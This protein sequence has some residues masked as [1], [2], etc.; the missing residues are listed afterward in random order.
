MDIAR[1]AAAL[2][3]LPLL[4]ACGATEAEAGGDLTKVTF[5]LA[6][7]P[8]GS[9]GG[10]FAAIDQG[11]YKEEG[12]SV[13]PVRGYG[14]TR[15][16]NEIDQGQFDYGYADPISVILNRAKKG[17][18]VM[19]GALNTVWP[20][21]LCYDAGKRTVDD[22]AGLKGLVLGGGSTSPIQSLLPVWLARNGLPADHIKIIKMD[23]AVIDSALVQ[24]KI[25][26]SDCWA[27]S[28]RATVLDLAK[29]AGKQIKWLDYRDHNLDMYGNGI[30]T[31]ADRLQ[32]DPEQVRKFLRATYKGY[33]Y[34]KANPDEVV[35]IIAKK[36]PE[37]NREVLASQVG[38][39]NTL[40]GDGKGL[41]DE[42]RMKS[43]AEIIG[44]AFKVD[45]PA[46]DVYTNDYLK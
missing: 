2:L 33:A 26:L 4:A 13:E 27:G 46:T 10:V 8:Q 37:M 25:D 34:M 24:G 20:G 31:S 45:V 30:V 38:D 28:N 1:R 6:W 43:T 35:G 17:G 36:Y 15:T 7:F 12:L 3:V 18:T 39:M 44:T 42:A 16:V 9:L 19:V 5:N 41:F 21:G 40:I 22:L 23:P 14:G 29:K 11:Y 32:K